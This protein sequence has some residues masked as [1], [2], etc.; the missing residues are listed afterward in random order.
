[1]F[2]LK[3]TVTFAIDMFTLKSIEV[4]YWNW[5]KTHMTTNIDAMCL[6]CI[7][8]ITCFSYVVT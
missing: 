5:E 3:I 6:I 7:S 2:A 1:M 8:G 4:I